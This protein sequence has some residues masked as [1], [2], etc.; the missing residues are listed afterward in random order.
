MPAFGS[1]EGVKMLDKR[2][3]MVLLTINGF[4]EEGSYKIINCEDLL[5]RIPPKMRPDK[6]GLADIISYLEE[7][8]YIKCKYSDENVYC[9]APLPKGRLYK[10]TLEE[11]MKSRFSYGRLV[12]MAFLGSVLGG[13]LGAVIHAIIISLLG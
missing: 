9:L 13:A 10:E 1:F 2:T 5:S 7:R 8:E 11:E 3:E 4:C 12:V 6:E